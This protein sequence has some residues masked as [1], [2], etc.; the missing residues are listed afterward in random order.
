MIIGLAGKAGSGK[1]TVGKYL[2]DNYNFKR[3]AF[4]DPLKKGIKELF[5]FTDDQLLNKKEEKDEYWNI[6]PR[7]ILQFFGT[8]I[9]QYELQKIIPDLDRKFFVKRLEK[10]IKETL[11][12]GIN[13]VIT[14]VRF[15]HEIEMIKKYNNKL[16][17]LNRDEIDISLGSNSGHISENEIS[18]ND[19]DFI[20][21]NNTTTNNLFN[22][23]IEKINFL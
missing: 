12:K 2:V 20:I 6:E 23:F 21:N 10:D 4:A 14:D 11:D 8:E 18:S 22:S 19:F 13:V 15:K 9:C 3:F 16:I 7:K 5:G 17:Y 1:D